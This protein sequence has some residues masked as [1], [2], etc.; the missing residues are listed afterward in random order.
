MMLK[1]CGITREEDARCVAEAQANFIGCV[2]VPGSPRAVTPAQ[3]KTLFEAAHPLKSVLVVRDMEPSLLQETI[4]ALHPY[5]VQ[6]HGSESAE[7]ALRLKGTR[8]W[9]AFNLN[10][11]DNL[12]EAM[13][14]PADMVVADSGGGTGQT[15]NWSK[16]ALLAS[17]RPTLLA[18]GI[19]AENLQA[20]IEAVRPIGIDLSSGVEEAPGLKGHDKIKA[21][22]AI[23]H[24]P[25]WQCSG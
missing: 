5:A 6:L 12:Q 11:L 17:Q 1:I 18:G 9:R 25:Q 13:D 3:A 20:A 7:Y 22:A 8:V 24:K 19:T 14:Y 2:L 4:N 15:C 16:A 10:R 21:V 23:I